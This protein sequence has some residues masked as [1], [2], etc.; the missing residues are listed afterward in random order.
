M[1]GYKYEPLKQFLDL[2]PGHIDEVTLT[3]AQIELVIGDELPPGAYRH[4][5]GWAND[6]G[7]P[8]AR[9]WLPDW[10]AGPVDLEGQ[11]VTF[12]RTSPVG[13]AGGEQRGPESR[14]DRL[15]GFLQQGVPAA[16]EITLGFGQIEAILGVDL[17]PSAR[18][19]SEWWANPS[20]TRG[21]PYAQAW[22]AAGWKVGTVDPVAGWVR[23]WRPD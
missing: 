3:F 2:T 21:H 19:Y 12:S 16:S 20:A 5:A 6:A 4:R 7:R 17:P 8:R 1:P 10:R 11:W 22:L 23:F 15:R 18:K 9:G 14:Y 13:G